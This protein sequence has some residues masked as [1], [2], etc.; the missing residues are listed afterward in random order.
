MKYFETKAIFEEIG[1]FAHS[2]E[3]YLRYMTRHHG[4]FS[5]WLVGLRL[6]S[7]GA[8]GDRSQA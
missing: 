1:T 7:A 3:E 5:A 8:F 2:T 6:R 4:F